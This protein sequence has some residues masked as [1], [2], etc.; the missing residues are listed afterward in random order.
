MRG[1]DRTNILAVIIAVAL[2]S[3][4]GRP[5]RRLRGSS[6]GRESKKGRTP[7]TGKSCGRC[8][9]TLIEGSCHN[10]ACASGRDRRRGG[11]R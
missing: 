11:G 6:A 3:P 4:F 9:K 5:G 8:G 2:F 10:N 1:Q 7:S